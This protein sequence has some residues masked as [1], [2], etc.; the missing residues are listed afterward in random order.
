MPDY[1]SIE[2]CKINILLQT[3]IEADHQYSCQGLK[4]FFKSILLPICSLAL[5]AVC[6]GTVSSITL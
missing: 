5:K 4:C 2:T 1:S 3:M 6:V